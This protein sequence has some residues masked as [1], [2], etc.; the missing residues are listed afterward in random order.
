[1]TS[2]EMEFSQRDIKELATQLGILRSR[3]LI[4]DLII[5]IFFLII[6]ELDVLL[7]IV[8]PSNDLY[9]TLIFPFL[10]ATALFFSLDLRN[11]NRRINEYYNAVLEEYKERTKE[12]EGFTLDIVGYIP[13]ATSEIQ[14]NNLLLITDGYRFIFVRDPFR[15]TI[16]RFKDGSNLKVMS[17]AILDETQFS[18]KVNEVESYKYIKNDGITYN[19]I[20]NTSYDMDSNIDK[21]EV[22][23]SDF[24]KLTFS[25]NFYKYLKEGNPTKEIKDE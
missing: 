11:F 15:N 1:M 21:V 12:Y 20:Y 25:A 10:L 23:L 18:F 2:E 24:K 9:W 4:I 8:L 3:K 16:Y 19:Q 22:V 17:D 13:D 14:S 7:F 5:A 6:M